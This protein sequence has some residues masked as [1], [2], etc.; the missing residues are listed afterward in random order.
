MKNSLTIIAFLFSCISFGQDS[1]NI[2]DILVAI[3]AV[4]SVDKSKPEAVIYTKT[5]P[6]GSSIVRKGKGELDSEGKF[7]VYMAQGTSL[8]IQIIARG[9][10]AYNFTIDFEKT[11]YNK[12]IYPRLCLLKPYQKGDV[13]KLENIQ[14]KQ[15]DHHLLTTS[16]ATLDEMVLL[17]KE[18]Q[19]MNIKLNGH[20]DNTGSKNALQKLSEDRVNEVRFYL[21]QKGIKATRIKTQGYG[22]TKPLVNN[23]SPENK[24]INR[25]VEFKILKL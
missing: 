14:F 3:Q 6:H 16:H 21:I 19:D 1:L 25:R 9:Y 15:G 5:R 23:N 12:G 8:D 22:G 10:N 20:T 13:I 4:D 11:P 17:M 18:N 7:T 24:A 2:R